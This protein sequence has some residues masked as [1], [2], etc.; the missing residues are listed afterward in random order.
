[1]KTIPILILLV[2]AGIAGLSQ[3]NIVPNLRG[4]DEHKKY[5]FGFYVGGNSMGGDVTL[6]NRIY[7]NDTLYSFNLRPGSGF[8]LGVIVDL[9]IG[10]YFDLRGMF[11]SLTFGQRDFEYRIE[12]RDNKIFKEVRSV[13]STYLNFPVE[14]K[15]KTKRYGNFRAYL[16]IGAETA[17]DLVSQAGADPKDKSVVRL[18]RYNHSY[19]YGFGLEFFLEYFK[20]A[21]Q[22]K[23]NR[24][25]GNMLINDGTPFTNVIDK[26][27]SKIVVVSLTFEG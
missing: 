26:V 16:I 4:F 6:N 9:H 5:H 11:P 10:P 12:T 27:N 17:L 2:F 1:M 8:N 15:Y 23:W 7:N 24:G 21:P 18:Q 14:L 13:E 25:F 22:I 20:F 19:A 3:R